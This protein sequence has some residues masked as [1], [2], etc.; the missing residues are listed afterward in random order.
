MDDKTNEDLE[1]KTKEE[2]EYKNPLYKIFKKTPSNKKTRFVTF[3]IML[4]AELCIILVFLFI[5]YIKII[6]S[7]YNNEATVL[8]GVVCL[9]TICTIV[10]WFW[11]VFE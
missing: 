5:N 8:F 3:F 6:P 11:V 10:A 1:D 4:I 9:T 7:K 2:L